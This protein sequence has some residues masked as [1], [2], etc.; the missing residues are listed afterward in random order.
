MKRLLTL[1]LVATAGLLVWQRRETELA[2]EEAEE[3]RADLMWAQDAQH[4]LVNE[5]E[6]WRG[7]A[8]EQQAAI[9][10]LL[11]VPAHEPPLIDETGGIWV[12]RDGW[13]HPRGPFATR[14]EAHDLADEE[15][16]LNPGVLVHILD[17]RET[18]LASD[19]PQ[20]DHGIG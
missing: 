1:A 9:T 19:E 3:I 5:R 16:R 8:Q 11:S 7:I 15:A 10:H 14:R 13:H 20:W 17:S 4:A 12:M 6:N 2:R 18:A